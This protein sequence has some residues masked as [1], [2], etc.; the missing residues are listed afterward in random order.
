M[1]GNGAAQRQDLLQHPRHAEGHIR[2]DQNDTGGPAGKLAQMR[3]QGLNLGQ[4]VKEPRLHLADPPRI[5]QHHEA[6][7]EPLAADIVQKHPLPILGRHPAGEPKQRQTP[8]G[9]NRNR[10]VQ[11]NGPSLK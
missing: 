4:H 1:H 11:N 5:R 8:R 2:F 6:G 3:R 10:I 9:K 7:G